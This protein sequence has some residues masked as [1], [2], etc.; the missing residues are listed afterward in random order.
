MQDHFKRTQIKIIT[1]KLYV[2]IHK[3]SMK[4]D[5][6]KIFVYQMKKTEY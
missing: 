5:F 4:C 1:M 6:K 2:N 3:S